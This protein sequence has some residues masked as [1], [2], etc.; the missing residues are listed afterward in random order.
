MNI[1]KYDYEVQTLNNELLTNR[2]S[3]S[4]SYINACNRFLRKAKS[5]DDPSLLGYAYYHLADAYYL[6]STDYRKFNTNLLKAIEYL[7]YSGDKEYLARCYNLLGIDSLNHGSPDLAL[8]YF[9]TGIKFCDGLENSGVPGFLEF[10]IGQIY[11]ESGNIKQALKSIQSAYKNIRR[12]EKE[13]LYYRNILY[14]YCFEA[15]CY[16]QLNKPDSVKKCLM[17]IDRLEQNPNVNQ[18]YIS[19]DSAI[20]AA[21]IRARGYY[22]IGDMVNFQKYVSKLLKMI[23]NNKYPLDNMEDIFGM[24]RFLIRIGW[25]DEVVRIV[26]NTERSLNDLNIH[27]LKKEHAKLK[28]ELYE[29]IGNKAERVKALEEFYRYSIEQ[30]KERQANYKFFTELRYKLSNMEKENITLQ[31]QATTDS[32]TGLGNRYGLNKFAD[33]AF[34]NAYSQ[35]KSL[36]V[37]IMDVDNFK[38]FNDTYGHQAGD[39][40]LTH[41]A[42]IIKELSD[43]NKGIHGFRYGGDEFVI[44]Y[45]DMTDDEVMNYARIIREK[46]IEKHIDSKDSDKGIV[47]VSQ[48]IRN[49][50]PRKANKLWDY[51]YAADNALYEVKRNS[52]G[53]VVLLHK[54]VISQKSLDDATHI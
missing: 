16:M 35:G 4:N 48:G 18:E 54:A 24:C 19:G 33:L 13:S 50:I 25:V 17:A 2:G 37:E 8:D 40:C 41:I 51:M 27:N 1:E 34:E 12:N 42:G 31:K 32:L 43:K 15:D 26:K 21:D 45:E 30:E 6:V 11:Y 44:I 10:N 36:A 20:T 28:C 5:V 46:V 29:S 47:T 38:N 23:Q 14:C 7:Q 52:K 9:L 39:D 22:F 3:M 53:E 49:S